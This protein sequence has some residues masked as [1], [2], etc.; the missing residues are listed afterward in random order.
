VIFTPQQS[1]QIKSSVRGSVR[2]QLYEILREKILRLELEP[3]TKISEKEIAEMLHISRTPVREA[4]L[5]LAQDELLNIIP[6]SGTLVS[7]INLEHVKEGRFIREIVEKEVAALACTEFDE[8]HLFQL[9]KN[10]TMQEL[11]VEKGNFLELFD[12]DEMFHQIIYD[13]C[14]MT[15][16]WKMI[17]N[18][19]IHFN[20]LR[21]L[22]LSANLD[23]E[24]IISHHKLIYQMI[25][26]NEADK[27]RQVTEKH[28]RLVEI[29]IDTLKSQFPHYFV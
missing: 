8:D 6:Q 9:E 26:N 1:Q 13:G 2:D 18:L 4:F 24:I 19:N 14:H 7:R 27:V 5:N 15:R 25:A 28:L 12:L 3:G 17:Q 11:C 20:R 10:F 16:T 23:W 21:V 22:S 29:E